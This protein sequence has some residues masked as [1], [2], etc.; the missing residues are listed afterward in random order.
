MNKKRMI[1]YDL[2]RII[3]AFSV[4][5][6]HSAAQ[7]WYTLEVNSTEWIVANS[8]NALVRIGVP[9][10]V[11]I[12][13]ALF[14]DK[15]YKLDIRRLYRHNIF[16]LAVLYVVWSC[17]YGLFDCMNFGFRQLEI[18]DIVREMLFGRYHLWF[19]PMLIGI[20]VLLPILKEW[21]AHANLQTIKYFLAVFVVLQIFGET[22]RAMTTMEEVHYLLDS[23][24]VELI[25][26]Y[27]GY[28]VWGYYLAQIGPEQKIR[29]A[30]C[31]CMVPAALCNVLLGN[32]LSLK[33]GT[34]KADIYDSYG[35][36]T[37]I[38][39]TGIY[40][41]V[42]KIAKEHS[43]TE[44]TQKV[45]VEISSNT[46]GIYLLHIGCMEFL[47]KK[48]IHSMMVPNVIGIPLCATL[49]FLL[50]LVIAAVLRRIPVLGKYLC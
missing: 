27:V 39:V 40:L 32:Y 20:Y 30:I 22:I 1:H 8:Y 24:K 4:V 18:K 16:R 29:K 50:C 36:F 19:L 47:E 43:F 31:I 12:S 25:C 45:V 49:C 48:G 6:L 11:M 28:F 3:A 2:L 38:I 26:S 10:F 5:M 46:L 41:L 17:A 33:A 35:L 23:A 7:F 21:L 44:R 9:I 13:G 34:A 42:T 14:L 15:E 37:F